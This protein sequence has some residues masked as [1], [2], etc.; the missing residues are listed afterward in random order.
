M[1]NE[2]SFS[3]PCYDQITTANREWTF[4]IIKH[5]VK[6]YIIEFSRQ[7]HN[8]VTVFIPLNSSE[9][10]IEFNL[11]QVTYTVSDWWS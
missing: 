9:R 5:L 8:V 10:H 2:M 3:Y 11:T 4:I 1:S 6:V 7:T